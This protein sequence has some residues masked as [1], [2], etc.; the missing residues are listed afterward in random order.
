MGIEVKDLKEI[1]EICARTGVV[2]LNVGDTSIKFGQGETAKPQEN[3]SEIIAPAADELRVESEKALI[4]ENV[5]SAED[6]L[7]RLQIEDPAEYE[8]LLIEEELEVGSKT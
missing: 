5:E 1:I 3:L 2:E 8:R 7:S 4:K 6:R